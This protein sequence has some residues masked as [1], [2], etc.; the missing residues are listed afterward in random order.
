MK[1]VSIFLLS[2]FI[3]LTTTNSSCKKCKQSNCDFDACDS[4]RTTILTA[5]NWSGQLGYFTD[6]NKWA[7]NYHLPNTIDSTLT[8]I[9][10]VDIADSLKQV[11]RVVIF[12]GDIKDGCGSP[13]PDLHGQGIFYINPTNLK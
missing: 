13:K 3:I 6:Q 11:G 8:C 1:I 5:T 4:R 7:I 12:S 9:I 10:C 2:A